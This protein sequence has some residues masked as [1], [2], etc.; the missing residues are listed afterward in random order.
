M[1]ERNDEFLTMTGDRSGMIFGCIIMVCLAF[2]LGFPTLG[3]IALG[4]A[5]T[6]A[7]KLVYLFFAASRAAY[8]HDAIA[9]LNERM[10][11]KK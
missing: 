1:V 11:G 2:P 7:A 5:G 3:G 9:S 8:E 4:T 10:H 6:L